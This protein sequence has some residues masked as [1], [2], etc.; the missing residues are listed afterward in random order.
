MARMG[1]PMPEL[2]ISRPPFGSREALKMNETTVS[3]AGGLLST[4]SADAM[5][6][7][8][9]QIPLG[10]IGVFF[11]AS[12]RS[13]RSASEREQPRWITMWRRAWAVLRSSWG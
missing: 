11:R 7:Q 8:G 13:G 10:P 6:P 4:S 1:T 12:L 5:L 2:G 9:E 3:R